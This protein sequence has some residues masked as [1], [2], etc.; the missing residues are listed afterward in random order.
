MNS[1]N[2]PAP[3][4]P[5]SS[6]NQNASGT[7]SL[8]ATPTSRRALVTRSAITPFRE[9]LVRVGVVTDEDYQRALEE[10]RN[11]QDRNSRSLIEILEE[12]SGHNLPPELVREFK[13]Q[14]L[15]ELQLLYGIESFDFQQ[16]KGLFETDQVRQLITDLMMPLELCTRYRLMPVQQVE[17]TVIIAMVD[18]ENLE[19]L[20]DL[21]RRLKNKGFT[22]QRIAITPE[23]YQVLLARCLDSQANDLPPEATPEQAEEVREYIEGLGDFL[24][25]EDETTQDLAEVARLAEDAPI[26]KLSNSILLR[27]IEQKVSDIHIEPQDEDLRIRFRKDGVLREAPAGMGHL[28]KKIIPA[29]LS[30]F[31]IMSDLNIAE[32]RVPQDGR[33]RRVYQNRT[34]DFRVSTLPSRYG[35]KMVLRLLDNTST[36]LG[37][38][39]LITDPST[40]AVVRDMVSKPYGLILVTGPTGS[41]KTTTLYSA[42]AERNDPGVNITTAEDPIEYT[43]AGISQVQVIRDKGM[44]FARILRA[45]LRQDPDIMLVGET[46]DLET[47][48]VSVEAALTG[49]LVLTTLHTNDAPGAIARLSEMGVEPFLVSSSLLGIVAQRLMRKVC[50]ECSTPYNPDPERLRQFGLVSA[51]EKDVIFYRAA[52]YTPQQVEQRRQNN[53]HICSSCNGVGYRG[54][55]GVYEVLSITNKLRDLITREASTELLREAAVE[56]GMNTL[57]MYSLNLVR[58]GITTLEEVERVTLSDS[59]LEVGKRRVLVCRTCEAELLPEWI[60]CPYCTTPRIQT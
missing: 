11:T 60:D 13:V 37:L 58:Q 14:Q 59:G 6:N 4:P 19:A 12:I 56:E 24:E 41:G 10:R 44:D 57:L 27:A 17:S 47:A 53:E 35:E 33:I 50:S 48:K 32:R 40:L 7:G 30:R 15:V 9:K 8:P 28:P 51:R 5:S 31:K 18:P 2:L 39:Q 29:L 34:I 45:F 26:I 22:L 43:M 38:D 42:L 21:N 23:D 16:Q 36:K 49:H 55:V 3:V 1:N 25:I 20:D 46:R 52:T 54:R